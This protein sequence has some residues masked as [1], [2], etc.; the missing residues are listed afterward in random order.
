[1]VEGVEHLGVARKEAE[2]VSVEAAGTPEVDAGILEVVVE[3]SEAVGVVLEN[4]E[5]AVLFLSF[6]FAD[7]I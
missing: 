2:L 5:G 1:M 7:L 4:R 3:I 6:F